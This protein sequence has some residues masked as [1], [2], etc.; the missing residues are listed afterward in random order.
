MSTGDESQPPITI[1]GDRIAL[2]PWQRAIVPLIVRWENDLALGLLAGSSLRAMTAER[3][4]MFYERWSKDDQHDAAHF[5]IYEADT[6]R[7]IGWTGLMEINVAHRTATYHIKIGE[8]DCWG[9][10]YGTETTVLVL[11]YAFNALNLHNVR[12]KTFSY[13]ARAIRAYTRA[14][15]REIGRRRESARFGGRVYDD[16]YMD[17]LSTD[18]RSPLRPVLE[19]P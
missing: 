12:L 9:K 11:D 15:F 4:E 7:L 10:G 6:L 19:L 17:C 1:R 5:L 16:V 13:N 8:T 18:F 2:G 3:A 14:G